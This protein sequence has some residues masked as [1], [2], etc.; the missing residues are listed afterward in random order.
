MKKQDNTLTWIII[1]VLAVL[2]FGGF[3]MMGF[4]F[5]GMMYGYGFSG[6]WIFGWMFMILIL[7][8]L[9]LF[10]TWLIKQLQIK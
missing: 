5:S 4:P 8:A 7:V 6:M 10:I 2:L 9:V 3:G 1:A